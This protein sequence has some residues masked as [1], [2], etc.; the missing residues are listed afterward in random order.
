MEYTL[1]DEDLDILVIEPSVKKQVAKLDVS[2]ETE[3]YD[4]Y[5]RSTQT[6]VSID[7]EVQTEAQKPGEI[8][9]SKK[10]ILKFLETTV[11]LMC[12]M[13]EKNEKSRAFDDYDVN[14][15]DENEQNK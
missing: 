1:Q 10:G 9:V 7:E 13:L 5:E 6:V 2:M 14:W 15:D 11:P 8:R 4:L 12:E 3:E